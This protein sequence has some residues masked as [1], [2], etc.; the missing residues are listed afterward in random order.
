MVWSALAEGKEYY[1]EKV[2]MQRKKLFGDSLKPHRFLMIGCCRYFD[3][4]T[5][6]CL[7]TWVLVCSHRAP[8]H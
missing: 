4:I 3:I 6:R 8:C 1:I 5:L 2:Q 7:W